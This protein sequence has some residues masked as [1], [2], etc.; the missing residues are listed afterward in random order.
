MAPLAR[1]T[2]FE[3][4]EWFGGHTNTVDLT[5]QGV[6]HGVDTGFLVFNPRTYPKLIALFADLGVATQV[7]WRPL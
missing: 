5:W 3:A 6:T 1:V 2:L 7:T 4:G